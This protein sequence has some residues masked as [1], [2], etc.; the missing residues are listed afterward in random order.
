MR[1]PTKAMILAAVLGVA[2][3]PVW[4]FSTSERHGGADGVSEELLAA[5]TAVD[6]ASHEDAEQIADQEAKEA[7][8]ALIAAESAGS[9]PP[10]IEAPPNFN[11]ATADA[12][13]AQQPKPP[14]GAAFTTFHGEM[15][16]GRMTAAD[17]PLDDTPTPVPLHADGIA[18]LAAQAKA[19]G[20][21][22]TF[23]W[24]F[25]T[26]T[27]D[28]T[29]LSK[30]LH[31]RG[32]D[33]LGRAA[34]VLR[35]Q[36]PAEAD[37]LRQIA[38]LAG[39]ERIAAT[40]AKDKIAAAFLA[41]AGTRPLDQT[42]AFVTLM[43]DDPDG[44][45]QQEL[46][47][48]GATVGRFDATIRV[49][50]ANVPHQAL[51]AIVAADFVQ[52]VE[53]I[54]R[55]QATHDAVVPAM[56][57]DA[58]RLFDDASGLFSG[59]NG[60]DVAIGVMDTGLNINHVDIVSNRRSI[61]GG[62][63]VS[64]GQ[65]TG[66]IEDQDLWIDVVGHGTHVTGTIAGNG[67]AEP[68]FAGMAP[69]VRDIRFAKVLGLQSGT[70]A[71]GL[72]RGMD[73]LAEASSCGTDPVA[74]KPLVVNMSLG[75]S[76]TDW[77]GRSVGERK[78]DA[79]VW[80]HQ[81]LYVVSAGNSAFR[82]RGDFASAKNSLTVGAT[83]TGGDIANF[84][85]HGP[86][87]DGRLKPQVVGPG[88]NL[89]SAAGNGSPRAYALSS[90]TSMSSPA[91]AGVAA[92]LMNA[93]PAFR[94]RPAVVRARLMASAI[95]PDAFLEDD[96]MFAAHN[97]DG[98]GKLQNIYG[99]GKASARTSVLSR[100]QED[101]WISGAATV[102]VGDGE[103]GYHD[104]EVPAGASRLDIVMTW[105]EPAADTFAQTL[106]NDL[107]LW[108][109]R[110]AD[111]GDA[112]PAAC[113]DAASRSAIDNVEWLVLRN[114][115]AGTYR[116]K[117]V[118]KRARVQTPRA[119][120]AWTIIR[121][122]STPQLSIAV[123]T[124]AVAVAPGVPFEVN[125]TLSADGYVAAG[126]VL[127]VDCRG[128]E[129]STACQRAEY[130]AS[131]AS[132]ASREDNVARSL[133]REDG[134][135]IALGE[136]AV[137]EEQ[138]VRLVFTSL[139][140]ADR[141][142]LYFT[143]TAW[144]ANSASTSVDVAVGNA[145]IA[146]SPLVA[147]PDNDAFATATRLLGDAGE[148]PFDLL[149]ATPEPGEPAFTRGLVDD[150]FRVFGV[151]QAAVRPRSI[152]YAWSAP[153][154]G[155]YRFNIA[156]NGSSAVAGS[157]A[158]FADNALSTDF[159]DNVQFDLFEVREDD[160][161]VSLASMSARVGGGLTFAAER[162]Q[163]YRIR[164]SV[165][166]QT[167]LP[168]P[169]A[170]LGPGQAPL[171]P[172]E[173]R[174]TAP[175]TLKWSEA[176]RPPND[177]F[178]LATA[179]SD[180]E[181][182]LRDS[183]FGATL[184]Q[185]EFFQP[186]AGTT[187]YRWRAPASGD[188]R[189]AID[190]QHLRV[191]VFIGDDIESLRLVSG[192]PNQDTVFPAGEGIEYRLLVATAD[193]DASGSEYTLRWSPD[194]RPDNN[195]DMANA[196]MLESLPMSY[197]GDELDFG[198]LTVEP[199]E[200]LASGSRTA[201]WRW[202]APADGTYTWRA[203]AV[204][205]PLQLSV[206]ATNGEGDLDL[207]AAS[208]NQADVLVSF[209]ARAEQSYLIAV[210]VRN[211]AATALLGARNIEFN[212]GPTPENDDLANAAMLAGRADSVF[213]SNR[214]ATV[215]GNEAAGTLGDSSLWWIWRA[216]EDGWQRFTVD[217]PGGLLAIFRLPDD[218]GP[219]ELIARSRRLD[220]VAAMLQATA[221]SRYAIRLGTSL[222]GDSGEF[223]LQWDA[224]EPP[225]WLRYAGAL[226]NGD[227]DGGG[228]LLQLANPA[229]LVMNGDGST[230]FA[231][232]Q[233]GLHVYRRNAATG[234]L[235]FAQQ[236]D[237]VS[238]GAFL[239]W[240]EETAALIAGSC[241]G[242]RRFASLEGGS[243]LAEPVF[244]Q[245]DT[246][247]PPRLTFADNSGTFV[248]MAGPD[249]I[250]GWR[251]D[252]G[253]VRINGPIVTQV[254]GAT[255]AIIGA[256][257]RFAYIFAD[258]ALNTYERNLETGELALVRQVMEGD[259]VGGDGSEG[260][261][262]EQEGA[263]ILGGQ[264]AQIVSGLSDVGPLAIDDDGQYLFAFARGGELALAFSLENPDAPEYLTEMGLSPPSLQASWFSAE[265]AVCHFAD[266]RSETLSADLA[267]RDF[268]TSVRLTEAQ[269]LRTEDE[270]VAGRG[271]VFGNPL[272][273]FNSNGA[274]VASPDDRHIY[275]ATRDG[276][277]IFARAGSR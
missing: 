99:L 189:V 156:P 76:D 36:L 124:E 103:Y 25:A 40:A 18:A 152:W 242:W 137:G 272:P 3:A 98:P 69:G 207:V 24:V 48:L 174:L 159:A 126:T 247:C 255:A 201:W 15:A 257:D 210:G 82:A 132:S 97:S 105:D 104:I 44:R 273:L 134:D 127:R 162:H 130:I 107:D 121:G 128:E 28:L 166:N 258:G 229:P 92:L 245:G 276:I 74:A 180:A 88:V 232:S 16:K 80:Q 173:R 246:G 22:W 112:Q 51:D 41:H 113:G 81:Q 141:F 21:P 216:P 208:R 239:L 108:V 244:L 45:W 158:D 157:A 29:A 135:R 262:T 230:L 47:R 78:L 270:L 167:L 259:F 84:S 53:P 236:L 59:N 187:W 42:P 43:T 110:D 226:L 171:T 175:L 163:A 86:T 240:D 52:A 252:E 269:T 83:E 214:F 19:A 168:R 79:T 172:G 267:C 27:A 241:D 89:A 143:A 250:S 198:S 209:T 256:D 222:A 165:T 50:I 37:R 136:V 212:W 63:F 203:D 183:N 49:Y 161:V 139:A 60:S 70:T 95:K 91:V 184:E 191:A 238:E 150:V 118:P 2:A 12:E 206:F 265:T 1:K 30:S 223:V 11:A 46:R 131:R 57:A 194:D 178:E 14:P 179:I 195:D 148:S 224:D 54:G 58:M 142:R 277:L 102:E 120:L 264:G 243:R 199:R 10:R 213:G 193:A 122:P 254:I 138:T 181:G 271:D 64:G 119:G 268:L 221:G 185:G 225:A 274:V 154:D 33:I 111:C 202:T 215:E 109:D 5:T 114:P 147:A 149:L 68:A 13:S 117:V 182:T 56:G 26:P 177:D 87:L 169:H 146:P 73:F 38:A 190:R 75:Q 237:G 61:C 32:V 94:E 35:A 8:L 115:P 228:T 6:S 144:N 200:P 17:Y 55:V 90:G 100:D 188:W 39:V 235:R 231:A 85:S 9:S 251:F 125:V 123:D 20:R 253:R 263:P 133:A 153:D 7:A 275:V 233:E 176:G 266:V 31:E 160:A 65:G 23:G 219:M 211:D 67:S 220:T 170:L 261:G 227:F 77:E 164:L 248:Y 71:A 151:A 205:A 116:L 66:R 204:D 93:V 72:S 234:E 155:V 106:L 217:S 197:H 4:W 129:G 145:E 101:G 34:G 218:G 186:L 62:N 196:R 140:E 249:G 96:A 260:D 192:E